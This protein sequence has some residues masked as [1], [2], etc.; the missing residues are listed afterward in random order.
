M[1]TASRWTSADSGKPTDNA[2]AESFNSTVRL[3]QHW[4][5]D[6]DDARQKVEEW[7]IWI[8]VGGKV[9]TRLSLA[10]KP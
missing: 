6:L 10:L 4:F 7:R 9:T 3:G 2:Y 5:L 8:R 1:R